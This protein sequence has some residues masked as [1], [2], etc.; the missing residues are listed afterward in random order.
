MNYTWRYPLWNV[1]EGLTLRT[2]QKLIDGQI[3]QTYPDN[4]GGY[5]YYDPKTGKRVIVSE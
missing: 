5:W 3:I 4:D 2:G 1:T